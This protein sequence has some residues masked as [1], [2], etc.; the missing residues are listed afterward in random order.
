[1]QTAQTLRI[2]RALSIVVVLAAI[3]AQAKVLA[4]VGAFDATRFGA[5][6]KVVFSGA[7]LSRDAQRRFV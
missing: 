7:V 2:V 6:V 4:D 1:M 5:S 3:L